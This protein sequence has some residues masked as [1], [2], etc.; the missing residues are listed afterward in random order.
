MK[1][2]FYTFEGNTSI[3]LR[4]VITGTESP[5]Q[6]DRVDDRVWF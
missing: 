1:V 3:Y 4:N 5:W 2:I 6:G